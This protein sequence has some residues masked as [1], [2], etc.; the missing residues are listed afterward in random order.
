MAISRDKKVQILGKIKKAVTDSQ[1]VVFVNFQGLNV[2]KAN[3][4]RRALQSNDISYTVAKKSL[5]KKALDESKISGTRP[6]LDGEIALAYG[7]D[8]LSPAKGIYDFGKEVSQLKI[9]GGIFDGG[10]M[11]KEA[12]IDIAQIPSREGLYSQLLYMI[13]WP[14]QGLAVTLDA[15][16]E[17]K[18]KSVQV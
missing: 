1:S 5:I 13:K 3:E 9:A 17:E 7:E 6:D 11:D 10:Y 14:I 8:L 16:A 2:A 18:A 12:M 15:I 4:L